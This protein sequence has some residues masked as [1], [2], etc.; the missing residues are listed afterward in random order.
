MFL[1]MKR[2]EW[3]F[4]VHPV[5]M[6]RQQQRKFHYLNQEL[7]QY[8]FEDVS[9]ASLSSCSQS[10]AACL[11]QDSIILVF[12]YHCIFS[13]SARFHV[14]SYECPCCWMQCCDWSDLFIL[15]PKIWKIKQINICLKFIQQNYRVDV[16]GCIKKNSL[17]HW[18]LQAFKHR[19]CKIRV[20]ELRIVS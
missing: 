17:T 3:R 15:I 19:T 16:N 7:K 1:N 10:L 18:G 8:L 4:W 2:K 9:G 20:L 5:L 6:R 11:R 13:T 14:L 12:L